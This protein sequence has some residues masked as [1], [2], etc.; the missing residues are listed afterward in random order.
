ML[1]V[2]PEARERLLGGAFGLRD[3]VLVM[4]EDQID[5]A[6]MDVDRRLAEQPQRH[7]RTLDV[8]AGTAG[9]G[10][11]ALPRRLAGLRRLPQHEVAGIVFGVLV[12]VDARAGM[13]AV[14]V[15]PRQPPVGRQRGD[16]EVDRPVAPV[17]VAVALERE[18]HLA[19]GV[20]VVLVGGARQSPRASRCRACAA[21]SRKA[22]IH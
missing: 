11:V 7:R 20:D 14:V 9:A 19:H 12:D 6:G 13:E 1:D 5:A 10:A 3:L 22:R 18:D 16:L 17:G 4:R 21:S 15:E 8:P 2:N